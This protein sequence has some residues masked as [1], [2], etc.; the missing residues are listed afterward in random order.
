MDIVLG[1]LAAAGAVVG[2]SASPTPST[3]EDGSSGAGGAGAT[4][5]G[6]A[7]ASGAGSS[8]G[9]LA[10]AAEEGVSISSFSDALDVAVEELQSFLATLV[11]AIPRLLIAAVV[12]AVFYL[13][14]RLVRRAV[15]PGLR[16][17]QGESFARVVGSI[18][19]GFVLAVGVFV[20][21]TIVF[22]SVSIS[23]LLGGAGVL[24]IAFAFAFQDILEN[25]MAGLLMLFRQPF[26]AGDQIEVDSTLEDGAVG[27]VEA[28]TIRETRIRRYDGQVVIVPNRQVYA[29]SIRVQTELAAIRSS[30][31][32]GC[33]YDDDLERCREVAHRAVADTQGVLVDDDHDVEP[34]FTEFGDSTIN[35][36]VRYWHV[37][38]QHDLRQVQD[39]VV[40]NL[41]AA[42]DEAGLNIPYTIASLEPRPALLRAL[43]RL[44]P[45]NGP[46]ETSDAS[47]DGRTQ[48]RETS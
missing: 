7:G 8:A 11:A 26:E 12:V 37:P 25:F 17:A 6:G 27:T 21:M 16:S 9:D 18:A 20:G 24:G 47:G 41:K 38:Q 36:D 35:L 19:F 44:G 28:I 13:V 31:I 1:L 30:M 39:R 15:R 46:D 45:A 42:F 14:A 48:V 4:G 22:P 5:A 23:T 34:Y 40:R 2:S 29:N 33:D 43:E 32:V 3:S 10:D